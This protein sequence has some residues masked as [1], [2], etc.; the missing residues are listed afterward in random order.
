MMVREYEDIEFSLCP[1]CDSRKIEKDGRSSKWKCLKCG[2]EDF[3]P[4]RKMGKAVY[5]W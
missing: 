1:K 2:L 4:L 5:Y 3:E